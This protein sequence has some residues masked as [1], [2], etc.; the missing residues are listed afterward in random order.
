MEA[1]EV[2]GQTCEALT[3]Q[4]YAANN[5]GISWYLM[6]AVGVVSAAGMVVYGRRTYQMKE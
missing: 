1:I 2:T 3:A 4:L 6:G 5:I